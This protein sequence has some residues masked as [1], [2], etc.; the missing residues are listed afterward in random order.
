[1]QRYVLSLNELDILCDKLPNEGIILLVG[2]LASGKTTLVKALAKK[3]DIK[4]DVTSPTFSIL[5]TY[6]D[7]LFH[8]DIYQEKTAGF[9]RQGLHEV[10]D[11]E[12]LHVIEWGDDEFEKML[13][14]M[15]FSYM[16]IFIDKCE[17][18]K[19]RIYRLSYA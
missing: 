11:D 15:G 12:K 14:N 3:F 8:Y 10:L 5:Q 13:Q 1:M 7:R 16:K 4:E 2:D 19:K 6:G 9:L 18:N 17:D